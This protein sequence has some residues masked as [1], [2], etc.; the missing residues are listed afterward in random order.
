[1][2]QRPKVLSVSLADGVTTIVQK[3]KKRSKSQ[4]RQRQT[5]LLGE[6]KSLSFPTIVDLQLQDSKDQKLS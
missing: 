4:G 3:E 1:M 2:P 5:G 6:K